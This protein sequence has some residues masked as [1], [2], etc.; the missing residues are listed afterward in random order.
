METNSNKLPKAVFICS[1]AKYSDLPAPRVPEYAILGRSNVG[2]SSFINHVLGNR[3]LARTSSTPGKTSLANFYQVGS[4]MVWVDLPGYGYARTSGSEKERWSRLIASYCEKRPSLA[5][6]IWLMDI[7]HIG[8]KN[9]LE[10]FAWLS[11]INQPVLPVLTKADKLNRSQRA[12]SSKK[13]KDVFCFTEEPVVYS[14][15]EHV[16]REKF[17]DRFYVWR[18][19]I[20]GVQGEP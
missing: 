13:A 19:G 2:K 8:V 3:F 5:G 10:A 1:A 16:S 4:G 20:T 7:R 9:D 14:V 17:W 18:G 12:Q 6:I 15:N 11:A